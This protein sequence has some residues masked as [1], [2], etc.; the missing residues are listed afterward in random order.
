MDEATRTVTA[1]TKIYLSGGSHPFRPGDSLP[2]PAS[3]AAELVAA[4]HLDAPA[5][6][7]ASE[8]APP[9]AA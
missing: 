9:P 8:P 1:Q 7:A 2:L 6:P 3:V 4:G 5:A